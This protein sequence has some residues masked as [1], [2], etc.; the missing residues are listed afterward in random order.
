MGVGGR[1]L[2]LGGGAFQRGRGGAL[3]HLGCTSPEDD[4]DAG[5]AW[6]GGSRGV[7]WDE[8]T[9]EGGGTNSASLG[10]F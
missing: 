2:G 6:G 10:L 4:L 9:G 8:V 7:R 5:G 1:G 3:K